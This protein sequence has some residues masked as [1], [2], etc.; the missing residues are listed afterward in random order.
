MLVL[1]GKKLMQGSGGSFLPSIYLNESA[2]RLGSGIV[3]IQGSDGVAAVQFEGVT[4]FTRLEPGRMDFF[5]AGSGISS[6]DSFMEFVRR[7]VWRSS[8]PSKR[9]CMVG[10]Y[11]A[12]QHA[13]SRGGMSG[14]GGRPDLALLEKSSSGK[15]SVFKRVEQPDLDQLAQQVDD[16]EK[17]IAA[18]QDAPVAKNEEVPTPPP[19]AG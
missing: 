11:W 15:Q 4:S 19:S 1:L 14:V 5:V 8:I 10:V 16:L 13:I 2:N 17:K 12:I 3:A 18:F 7:V 6:G 9:K